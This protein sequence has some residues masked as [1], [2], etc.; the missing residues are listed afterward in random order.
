MNLRTKNN[1]TVENSKYFYHTSGKQK[2][3]I[4]NSSF[5]KDRMKRKTTALNQPWV[6][7]DCCI[8]LLLLR[9][10][11]YFSYCPTYSSSQAYRVHP[12]AN[13]SDI[14]LSGDRPE[15]FCFK[16]LFCCCCYYT[17]TFCHTIFSFSWLGFLPVSTFLRRL[18]IWARKC[19]KDWFCR[20]C[21]QHQIALSISF[22]YF[23]FSV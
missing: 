22:I 13:N 21:H 5:F 3:I 9:E 11:N 12:K 17:F 2:Q 18:E 7:G 15:W 4:K 23:S 8:Q 1:A 6:P 10:I 14:A 19:T 16:N 20:L